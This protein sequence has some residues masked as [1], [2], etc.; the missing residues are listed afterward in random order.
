MRRGARASSPPPPTSP[1]ASPEQRDVLEERGGADRK[2]SPTRFPDPAFPMVHHAFRRRT[3]IPSHRRLPIPSA[4][5]RR[6]QGAAVDR[7]PGAAGGGPRGLVAVESPSGDTY[8]VNEV[9]KQVLWQHPL[10]YMYQQIY[11]EEKKKL[12][13][14]RPTLMVAAARPSRARPGSRRSLRRQASADVKPSGDRLHPLR[15][16]SAASCRRAR[17]VPPRAGGDRRRRAATSMRHKSGHGGRPPLRHAARRRPTTCDS[18]DAC[19]VRNSPPDRLESTPS[20]QYGHPSDATACWTASHGVL[21]P[22]PPPAPETKEKGRCAA[23]SS[24]SASSNGWARRAGL[25]HVPRARSKTCT[26]SPR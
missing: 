20:A 11:I 2:C 24:S 9:T 22:P 7:R 13:D 10:D 23:S 8:Y 19:R 5:A 6:G 14:R 15:R 4:P 16:P 1:A 3:C 26:A 18:A 12:M 21:V 17:R 25:L